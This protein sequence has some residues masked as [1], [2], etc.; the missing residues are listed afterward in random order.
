M[1]FTADEITGQLRNLGVVEGAL[2]YV[3]AS[4]RR[5]GPVQGKAQG[6]VSAIDSAVGDTGTWM[7]TLGSQDDFDWTNEHPEADR[8]RL[9][10]RAPV[11]DYLATPVLQEVGVLA[12]VMRTTPGT[13]V[14]NHPDGRFAARGRLSGELL[15][16]GPWDDYY[17]PGSALDKFVQMNGTVLRISANLD[18]VTLLHF[19]EYLADVP[20]K[21]RVV[22]HHKIR[23]DKG[24]VVVRSCSSLDDEN[25][26]VDY[27]GED[28]FAVITR[29]FLESGYA[30]VGR[31][32]NAT[33]ELL[34]ARALVS[35]GAN[36]MTSHLQA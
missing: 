1:T 13:V 5:L 34:D 17:G 20:N 22:R 24:N 29:E 7:M 9:R 18:T 16:E 21:T 14:N 36:W 2:L 12:E 8:A 27:T 4:L 26:I 30:T 10:E 33:C 35:F 28:Y 32:G 31:V 15:G 19:A 6:V 23:D 3:H 25:G 11:F